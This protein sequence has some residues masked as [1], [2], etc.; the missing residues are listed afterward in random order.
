MLRHISVEEKIVIALI[1]VAALIATY[2]AMQVM[3]QGAGDP[4]ALPPARPA[5]SPATA[6]PAAPAAAE[7]APAAEAPGD[8]PKLTGEPSLLGDA[9]AKESLRTIQFNAQMNALDGGSLDMSAADIMSSTPTITAVDG[10]EGAGEGV[11]GVVASEHTLLLVTASASGNWF[12]LGLD[13]NNAHYG[14]APSV[15]QIDTVEEC[16]DRE[17]AWAAAP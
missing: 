6:T 13:A 16:A 9:V 15:D 7:S 3:G 4:A 10:V 5:A 12:C 1:A 11:V 14:G 2:L 17:G 8:T